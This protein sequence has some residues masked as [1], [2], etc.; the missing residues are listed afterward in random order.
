[1]RVVWAQDALTVDQSSLEQGDGIVEP[2]HRP[3]GVGEVVAR[4]QGV[5]VV[6]AQDALTIGQN[7]LE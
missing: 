6:W 1:M 5:G 7:L 2:A 4:G 3:V